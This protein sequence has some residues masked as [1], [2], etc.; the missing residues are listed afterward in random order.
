VG[1]GELPVKKVEVVVA[2][3]HSPPGFFPGKPP[4]SQTA[5]P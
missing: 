5:D 3:A 1:Y 4:S 2:F